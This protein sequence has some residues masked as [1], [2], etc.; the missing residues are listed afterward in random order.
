M[1]RRFRVVIVASLLATG[2]TFQARAGVVV[3]EEGEKKIEI[4]GQIQV[5]YHQTDPDGGE[6]EDELFFR[7]LR[8]YIAGTIAKNWLGKIEFDFGNSD[9]NVKDA[10]VQYTGWERVTMTLGNQKPPYSREFLTSSKRQQFVER[11]FVGDHNYGGP[12]RMIAV[13]LDGHSKSKKLAWSAS[14]GSAEI[15]P[16]VSKLDFDSPATSDAD[17]NQGLLIAGR[18]DFHPLGA[19]KYDQSDFDRKTLYT[20]SVGGFTW[21]ND[22]DNNTYTVGGVG[23]NAKKADVDSVNGLELSA[24][25]RSSGLSLDAQYNLI[26][27]DS[28]DGSFTGGI[29]DGGTADLDVFAL[30]GGYMFPSHFEL[31]GAWEMLDADTYAKEWTRTSIGINHYYKK[32]DIKWQLAYR[33]GENV[34]GVDGADADDL[35]LM[36]QLVF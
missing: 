15:D 4:G 33:M 31:V 2:V 29:F 22:D 7:R 23:T 35:F 12:D 1:L 25:L 26:S 11:T 30:E 34:N 28:V 36:F 14:A 21:A 24:G 19:M 16:D 20:L 6:S 27:A 17:F 13:K 18:L 5:Q 32:H 8:P 3:Y 9:V 10:F